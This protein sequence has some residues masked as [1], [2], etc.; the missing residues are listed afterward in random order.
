M[1]TFTLQFVFPA[2]PICPAWARWRGWT[3]LRA[4]GHCLLTSP[5][6]PGR[7]SSCLHWP[8]GAPGS[9]PAYPGPCPGSDPHS[10]SWCTSALTQPESRIVKLKHDLKSKTFIHT[11]HYHHSTNEFKLNLKIKFNVYKFNL[12]STFAILSTASFNVFLSS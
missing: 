9:P 2:H 8:P 11:H 10:G 4:G 3:R 5:P 12:T 6:G 7:G 1:G